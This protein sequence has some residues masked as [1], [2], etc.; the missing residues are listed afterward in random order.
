MNY[1]NL[2]SNIYIYTLEFAELLLTIQFYRQDKKKLNF[3][4]YNNLTF[5][6]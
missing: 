2:I 4:D 3:V 1:V 6:N 5:Y